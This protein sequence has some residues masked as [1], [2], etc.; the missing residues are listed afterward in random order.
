LFNFLKKKKNPLESIPSDVSVPNDEEMKYSFLSN[1]DLPKGFIYPTSFIKYIK[2]DTEVKELEPYI[3][4]RDQDDVQT[5]NR[6]VKEQ[7]PSRVLVPFGKD[8]YSDDVFCF[9]GTDTSGN[10]KVYIVHTYASPGWED[11]GYVKDFSAWLQF[12]QEAHDAY[13]KQREE[14]ENHGD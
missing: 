11:K 13:K 5:F 4:F 2:Y 9:D 10:P 12:A 1:Q 7:Y 14:E 6:V 3:L 8:N